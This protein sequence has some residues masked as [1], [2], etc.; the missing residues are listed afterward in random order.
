VVRDADELNRIR[1]Y[2][3]LNPLQWDLDRENPR[4]ARV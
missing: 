2:I 3:D 4:N 1:E